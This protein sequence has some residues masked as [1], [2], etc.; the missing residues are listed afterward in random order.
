MT[1]AKPAKVVLYD[2]GPYGWAAEMFDEAGH[3]R[4]NV[5]GTREHV[6]RKVAEWWPDLPT[7]HGTKPSYPYWRLAARL[8]P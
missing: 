2:E 3:L 8:K 4:S 7:E 5:Y 6:D 1:R